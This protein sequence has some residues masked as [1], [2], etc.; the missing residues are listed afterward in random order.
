MQ[1]CCIS[2]SWMG[3]L[4][5]IL[6]SD[7]LLFRAIR[8]HSDLFDAH[9]MMSDPLSLAEEYTSQEHRVLRFMQRFSRICTVPH[10]FYDKGVRVGVALN[11]ST[12]L[13]SGLCVGGRIWR[14]MTVNLLADRNYCRQAFKVVRIVPAQH[15]WRRRWG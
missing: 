8:P 10:S 6:P 5:R 12:P 3:I 2:T 7:R 4:C 13:R 14:I 1:I 9:L 15:C 11:P